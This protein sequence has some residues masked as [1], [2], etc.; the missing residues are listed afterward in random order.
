MGRTK[1]GPAAVL[2]TA[3]L[4]ALGCLDATSPGLDDDG[5]N[6]E[7]EVA[8]LVDP[9]PPSFPALPARLPPPAVTTGAVPHQQIDPDVF[10]E[11]IAS[12]SGQIFAFPEV[13]SRP[14][15]IVDD[16]TAIW[17]TSDFNFGRPE[18]VIR[19]R[20]LGHIHADGS[21]HITLPHAR[22]PGAADAGWIERHPWSTTRPRF[23]AYVMVFTPRD[24]AEV[25]LIVDLVEVAI[26]FVR[27]STGE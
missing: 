22:I 7:D 16:A 3:G 13:E 17:L 23:S 12:M 5:Q 6:P 26:D 9:S 24:V 18:C 10:P 25:E 14:S 4:L 11:L 1:R 2:A 27:G 21:L 8:C 19:E 20:E 15:T